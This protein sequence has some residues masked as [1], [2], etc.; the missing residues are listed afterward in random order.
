MGWMVGAGI[1]LFATRSSPVLGATQS[2][3]QCL[4]DAFSPEVKWPDYEAD[5]SHP[6]SADVKKPRSNASTPPYIF[7]SWCLS[8][9]TTFTNPLPQHLKSLYSDTIR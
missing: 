8:T 7:M 9:E 1:I 6:S 4:L 2:T 3:A 5:H